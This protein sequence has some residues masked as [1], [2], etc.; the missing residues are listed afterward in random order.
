MHCTIDTNKQKKHIETSDCYKYILELE[1]RDAFDKV[2]GLYLFDNKKITDHVPYEIFEKN[3]KAYSDTHKEE[4]TEE[5][6]SRG[7]SDAA[8]LSFDKYKI[9]R[10]MDGLAVISDDPNVEPMLLIDAPRSMTTE[11]YDV[12]QLMCRKY[13]MNMTDAV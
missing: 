9:D 6:M 5:E 10:L 7:K 12:C 1:K 4:L 3:F 8:K 2:D 13:Q 11:I